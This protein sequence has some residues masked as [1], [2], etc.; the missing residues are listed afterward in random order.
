MGKMIDADILIDE[1][2]ESALHHCNNPREDSLLQRDRVIV[3]AQPTVEAIPKDQYE[4]RLKADMIAM[5]EDLDL[6]ID[7]FNS[8]CGWDGYIKKIDVH[9]LIQQKINEYKSESEGT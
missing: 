7:E 3:R 2:K 9:E 5:L 1:L 4:T 6:Q 8:G